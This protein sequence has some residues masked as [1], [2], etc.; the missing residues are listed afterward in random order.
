[1]RYPHLL[2]AFAAELWALQPEKLMAIIDLLAFQAEGGKFCGDEIQARI[3]GATANAIARREGSVAVVPLRGL[4]AGRA[5][6]VAQSSTG[7]G[8][9]AEDFARAV[10]AA[11]E[12]SGVKA[13]VLDVDSPGG[14]T[15]MVDEAA[16]AVFDARGSKPI[17]AQVSATAASA[18]YWIA[19]A[20]DEIVV[21]PSGAVGSIG[22][23]TVH[24]DVSAKLAAEGVKPTLVAAGR[25]KG[26]GAPFAELGD[27]ARA[28]LQR[29][30]DT[31][32]AQFVDRVAQGRGVTSASVRDGFGQ[33]RMVLAAAAVREGM[34]DRV[35]TLDQTLAR[36]GV[37][38][39]PPASAGRTRALAPARELR[40]LALI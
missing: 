19:A 40:A 10:T 4:I 21:T 33:G 31:V 38:T 32:Y 30:V 15:A 11:R 20:A 27:D 25:Y 9:N 17:I 8:T 28:D 3:A 24:E 29:R 5:P 7:G 22:V 37:S 14:T 12:D 6:M 36:F 34:A 1:M 13:V 35:A 39:S 26:E 16:Q 2:Q 18:A 23:Y